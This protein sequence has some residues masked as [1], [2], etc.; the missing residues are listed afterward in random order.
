M[1]ALAQATCE[2]CGPHSPRVTEDE[3]AEYQREIPE[4]ENVE[5]EGVRRLERSFTFPDFAS[6]LAF[7]NAVGALAEAEGHHPSL[8]TEWGKVM[9]AWW[10]HAI[11]G[12]HKNDFIMA[13]RTDDA[14]AK[15]G[16]RR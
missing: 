2:A 14:Y 16:G 4:W 11:R 7:T 15:A 12:L 8:Q 3:A 10:T 5:R 1:A 6:A 13:A 9:V